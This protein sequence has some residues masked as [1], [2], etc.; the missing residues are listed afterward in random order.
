E[1]NLGAMGKIII[2]DI[3]GLIEGASNGVGLGLQFL[4]HIEKTKILI[5]CID[6]QE[7]DP[8]KA[9]ETVIKE[10]KE[11]N[12]TLLEK[13]EVILL[14]K[15]DLGERGELKNK[16]KLLKKFKREI[17]GVS[18]YDEESISGIKTRIEAYR[19]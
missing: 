14:T 12:Q 6:S 17:V 15:T 19:N 7:K 13:K 1:P 8:V 3:P 9:Y 5:H 2:S 4:K 16:I 18:I 11:Y 10:F